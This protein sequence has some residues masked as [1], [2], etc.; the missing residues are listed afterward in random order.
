LNGT[1]LTN[2]L[3]ARLTW[4][5]NSNNE[6]L[7]QVWRSTN[8]GAFTQVGTVNRSATQRTATGGTVTF[9]QNITAGNAYSYY[10]IAVNT[11]PNPDQVSAPSNTLI[12]LTTPAAPSNLAGSAVRTTSTTTD[13]ATLTWTDNSTNES[14]FHVQRS[15]SPN[16][17]N[18]STYT[19]A[20]NVTTFSQNVSRT[21]N[22]YYRVRA[23]NAAG[24][25]AWSNV[26]FVTTP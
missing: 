25:S 20:A 17:T 5:D 23:F 6:N 14:G 22:Y 10:V 21:Q 16:F 19:M 26:I 9:T 24:N 1:L 12:V 11:V 15:T 13:R 7:F 4:L 3:R 18:T 2:P 8:G